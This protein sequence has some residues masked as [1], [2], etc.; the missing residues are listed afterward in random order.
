M[1]VLHVARVLYYLVKRCRLVT[2]EYLVQLLLILH[3]HNFAL[4]I[5]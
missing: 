3:D 4:A 5:V 2:L 1:T